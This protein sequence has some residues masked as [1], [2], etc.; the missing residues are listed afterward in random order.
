[1]VDAKGHSYALSR[2]IRKAP[3]LKTTES[4]IVGLLKHCCCREGIA[5]VGK[6]SFLGS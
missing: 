2:E 5:K 1:M 3:G 4:P 6:R